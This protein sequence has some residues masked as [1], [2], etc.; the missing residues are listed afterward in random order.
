MKRFLDG[1]LHIYD[2][3]R[4]AVKVGDLFGIVTG[5]EKRLSEKNN[6]VA[7]WQ[8]KMP[9][10]N[11]RQKWH[12]ISFRLAFIHFA[13]AHKRK[14]PETSRFQDLVEISGIEPLTSW[15][16]FKCSPKQ[17]GNAPQY[18]ESSGAAGCLEVENVHDS[19]LPQEDSQLPLWY[20]RFS[21]AHSLNLSTEMSINPIGSSW[22]NITI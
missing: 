3:G 11:N 15:M 21:M 1:I 5:A 7:P 10:E 19:R 17:Y 9:I 2:E 14:S 20:F 16:P 4:T 22:R 8:L 12:Y 18:F 13:I 6:S